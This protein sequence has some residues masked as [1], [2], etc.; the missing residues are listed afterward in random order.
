MCGTYS[1]IIPTQSRNKLLHNSTSPE[2]LR[3]TILESP[4]PL[5]SEFPLFMKGD[6]TLDV[7]VYTVWGAC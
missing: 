3:R 5:L 4:T 6:K 1:I 7:P 2:E